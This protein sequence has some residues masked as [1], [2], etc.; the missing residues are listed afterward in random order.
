MHIILYRYNRFVEVISDIA[1]NVIVTLPWLG[2]LKLVCDTESRPTCQDGVTKAGEALRD[3]IYPC[4]L[5][6]MLIV[7]QPF[8]MNFFLNKDNQMNAESGC[9]VFHL[10]ND[11]TG[12]E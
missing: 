3:A 4:A 10:P 1:S 5:A 7:Y 8:F 9:I 2:Y 12:F 6:C 11:W